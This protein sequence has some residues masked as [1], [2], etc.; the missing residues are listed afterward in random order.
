M[1][2]RATQAGCPFSL[3]LSKKLQMQG[4]RILRSE[5]Y[6]RYAAATKDERNAADGLLSNSSNEVNEAMVLLPLDPQRLSPF[7]KGFEG[8]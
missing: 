1:N 4:L 6:N 2:K 3:W 5:A 7:T 8:H